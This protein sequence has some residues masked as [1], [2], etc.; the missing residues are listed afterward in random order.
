MW[1]EE[2][3][4]AVKRGVKMHGRDWEKIYETKNKILGRR[5]PDS[6]RIRYSRYLE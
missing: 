2:E 1:T 3:D 5:N 6:I 4:A